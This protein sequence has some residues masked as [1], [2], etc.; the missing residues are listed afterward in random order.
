[1]DDIKVYAA[2]LENPG[3]LF[4][5]GTVSSRL[6]SSCT[7]CQGLSSAFPNHSNWMKCYSHIRVN[8]FMCIFTPQALGK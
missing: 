1:M 6:S 4:P 8:N 3:D 7:G 2:V 5:N